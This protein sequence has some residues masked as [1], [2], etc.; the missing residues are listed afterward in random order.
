MQQ[1]FF[2]QCWQSL[3][4]T[5]RQSVVEEEEEELV[6]EEEDFLNDSKLVMGSRPVFR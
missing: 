6:E 2:G 3:C 4:V 5:N 1:L